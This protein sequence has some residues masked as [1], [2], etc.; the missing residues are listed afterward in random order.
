MALLSLEKVSRRFGAIV[1]ADG[2]N[3]D[4]P[5]GQALGVL[6]P[7]GA[8]TTTLFG[9][10]AGAVAPDA[11]RIVFDGV[12]VTHR[13]SAQR[14]RLGIARS[15]QIPQ[16]F[17][18]MSVFENLEVAAR[19]GARL[20]RRQAEPACAEILQLCGL[21]NIANRHAHSLTLLQRKRLELARAL[22]SRPKL[23][24][25][26]E[27]AGGLSEEECQSLVGLVRAV[28]QSGVTIVWVEH[29]VHAL[30]AVVDRLVVLHGGALIADGL[31]ADVV[32]SP[33]V[34]EIYMGIPAN[35]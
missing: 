16:P 25:L 5:R 22:A 26:D 12:D 1:V 3:L 9:M 29:I 10:I 11:G 8:G 35:A 32:A 24:L 15:F 19:L 31:P 33:Q 14:C 27:V 30:I 20:G 4:V 13:S 21:W 23:L 6:G 34:A 28:K 2:V 18:A 7:N 17:G